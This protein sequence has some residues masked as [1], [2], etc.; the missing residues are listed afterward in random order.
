M[1]EKR[2]LFQIFK[3][4][5]ATYLSFLTVY[6]CGFPATTSIAFSAIMTASFDNRMHNLRHARFWHRL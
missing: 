3:Y 4:T 1:I 6:F 5:A 2:E